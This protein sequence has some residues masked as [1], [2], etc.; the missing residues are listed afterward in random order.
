MQGTKDDF[1]V[2]ENILKKQV[3]AENVTYVNNAVANSITT[4]VGINKFY[5]ETEKEL[6]TAAQKETLRKELDYHKGFLSSVEKKLSNER[7]VQNAKPEVVE[8]ERKKK[9]DAEEKIK[10]LEEGLDNLG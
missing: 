4:V 10:A 1:I 6:D 9:N 8:A 7:F 5:I 3:N 2:I